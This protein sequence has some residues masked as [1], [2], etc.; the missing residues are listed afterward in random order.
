[1][2]YFGLIISYVGRGEA[3]PNIADYEPN[4]SHVGRRRVRQIFCY[5][6][7]TASSQWS[8]KNDK[9]WALFALLATSE[10]IVCLFP[11]VSTGSIAFKSDEK[12]ATSSIALNKSDGPIFRPIA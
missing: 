1:M 4:I 7:K 10:S 2:R 5:P 6:L 9:E 3:E 12:K 11:L 8:H